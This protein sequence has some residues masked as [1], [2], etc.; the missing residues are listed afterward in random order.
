M[1]LDVCCSTRHHHTLS[2]L[3]NG[4]PARA[5]VTGH[6]AAPGHIAARGS[7][8]HGGRGK[9]GHEGDGAFSAAQLPSSAA[10]GPG[11]GSGGAGNPGGRGLGGVRGIA[12]STERS[13]KAETKDAKDLHPSWAARQLAKAAQE[14]RLLGLFLS[15]SLSRAR[16]RSV[17]RA[18]PLRMGLA[19]RWEARRT[20]ETGKSAELCRGV[21]CAELPAMVCDS[22]ANTCDWCANTCVM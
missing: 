16:A 14:K 13:R 3:C 21:W 6:Q 9:G 5:D 22:W 11:R 2:I 18:P 4:D 12:P 20:A 8:G 17:S 7:G 15:L 1:L 19:W 10:S